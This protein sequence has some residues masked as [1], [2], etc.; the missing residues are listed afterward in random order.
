M[1]QKGKQVNELVK[2]SLATDTL[3]VELTIKEA[4]AL[5]SGVK[6]AADPSISKDARRK[7]LRSLDQKLFPATSNTIDYYALE[8]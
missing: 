7:V 5:S 2:M 4:F 3:S 8:V 1:R 6:F